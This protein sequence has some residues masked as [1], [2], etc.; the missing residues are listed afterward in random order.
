MLQKYPKPPIVEAVLEMRY[1][2]PLSEGEVKRIPRLLSSEFP[3]AKEEYDVELQMQLASPA[4]LSD[5][6]PTPPKPKIVGRGYRL[7]D[8]ADQ[9]IVVARSS[10][11]I[12]SCLAP[13]P[14]WD[15]FAHSAK[16]VFDT[17]RQKLGFRPLTKVG[18]RYLNRLDIPLPPSGEKLEPADYLAMSAALPD[19]GM[20]KAL[21]AFQLVID[22]DLTHDN[23]WARI[24]AAT[25]LPALID[26]GALL[27]DIDVMAD[28]DVP[29]KEE[30][31]WS[32]VSRMRDAKNTI[33]ESC[34]TDTAR[35]LFGA[36]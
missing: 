35:K 18:L 29:Q 13:Y 2:R 34:V 16:F 20:A 36:A 1:G 12:F 27:L 24:Q 14:G 33:F 19:P 8:S 22:V 17:L 31:L 10:L 21:R 5:P 15:S 32:L 9:K 6:Q 4:A 26:H 3:K 23:L 28:H 25:A 7:F 30:D 11:T